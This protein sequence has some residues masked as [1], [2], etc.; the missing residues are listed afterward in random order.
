MDTQRN[1]NQPNKPNSPGQG[2][3][4]DRDREERERQRRERVGAP[5]KHHDPDTIIGTVIDKSRNDR[6]DGLETIG[7]LRA[8]L[9]VLRIHAGRQVDGDHEVVAAPFVV[10]L[11]DQHLRPRQRTDE[12][13]DAEIGTGKRPPTRHR[14]TWC[15]PLLCPGY[16][17]SRDTPTTA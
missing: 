10:F 12:Q 11:R 4:Q 15:M 17:Q 6:L 9:E 13:R 3:Q 7:G 1:P 8:A 5:T 2:G 16:H 14:W